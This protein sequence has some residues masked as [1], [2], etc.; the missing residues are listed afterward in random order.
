VKGIIKMKTEDA[1][2]DTK[3]NLIIWIDMEKVIKDLVEK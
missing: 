3:K 1:T 2:A